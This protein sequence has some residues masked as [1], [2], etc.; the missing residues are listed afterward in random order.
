MGILQE[1]IP[2]VDCHSLLLD[3]CACMYLCAQCS[4][5]H[6]DSQ[7]MS[8]WLQGLAVAHVLSCPMAC[9][10]LASLCSGLN[11]NFALEGEF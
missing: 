9:G 1:R 6:L 2:G 10:L 7:N 8:H 3:M 4:I 5:K 11:S